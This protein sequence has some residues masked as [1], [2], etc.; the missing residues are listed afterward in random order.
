MLG[1]ALVACGGGDDDGD[2]AA[3]D[4]TPTD[5]PEAEYVEVLATLQAS[6]G[7]PEEVARCYSEGIVSAIGVDALHEAGIA[8]ADFAQGSPTEQGLELDDGTADE[9]AEALAACGVSPVVE[10]SLASL[11]TDLSDGSIACVT[12]GLPNEAVARAMADD[13]VDPEARA[14][15]G[16]LRSAYEGCPAAMVELVAGASARQLGDPPSAEVLEC[17]TEHVESDTA[18]AAASFVDA[19]AAEAFGVALGE[20]CPEAVGTL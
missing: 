14:F 11:G 19:A 7:A 5:A 16:A 10:L 6:S 17:I 9:I 1:V 2:D 15:V 20:A 4:R 13:M 18:A 3:T 8:P 12:E